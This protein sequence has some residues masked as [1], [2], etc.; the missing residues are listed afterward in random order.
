MMRHGRILSTPRESSP[1]T[2]TYG[3]ND[4]TSLNYKISRTIRTFRHGLTAWWHT[5]LTRWEKVVA[6]QMREL[7]EQMRLANLSVEDRLALAQRRRELMHQARER[8][9]AVPPQE[10]RRKIDAAI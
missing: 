5:Q 10:M 1:T 8:T 3:T 2:R 9:K 4:T 7:V 6:M